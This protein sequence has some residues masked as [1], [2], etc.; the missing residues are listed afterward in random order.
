MNA[1]LN[2]KLKNGSFNYNYEYDDTKRFGIE[3]EVEGSGVTLNTPKLPVH[4]WKVVAD[5]SLRGESFEAVQREPKGLTESCAAVKNFYEVI[6]ANGAKIHDSM[7]AGLHIHLNCQNITLKRMFTFMTAYYCIEDMLVDYLGEERA[8]NLF[9]LRLSDAE[10]I[11]FAIANCLKKESLGAIGY[12]TNDNLRYAAMNLVSLSKFGTLEFRA[13]RTPTTAEPV[14]EWLKILDRLYL[15]SKKFDNPAA[16]ISAMS[17]NGE[18]EVLSSLLPEDFAKKL[19]NR[20]DFEDSLYKAI[21]NI[22]HWVF[23]TNWGDK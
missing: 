4:E 13:M 18:K 5:G 20:P 3:I 23:R 7:R 2:S 12:F 19:F 21:R 15:G 17:A 8:G 1:W 14:I 11:S 9:C 16:L 6:T 22:Q 10:D